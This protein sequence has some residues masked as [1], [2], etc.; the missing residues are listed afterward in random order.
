MNIKTTRITQIL[1]YLL[2]VELILA[3]VGLDNKPL[4][5]LVIMKWAL[6]VTALFFILSIGYFFW[7]VWNKRNT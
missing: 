3:M 5:D 1:Y 7:Q 2:I 4:I 6:I